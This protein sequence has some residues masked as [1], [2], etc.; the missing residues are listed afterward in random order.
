MSHRSTTLAQH[1]EK[2]RQRQRARRERLRALGA[3]LPHQVDN[4]LSEAVAFTL[5]VAT[6]DKEGVRA[7]PKAQQL[8]AAMIIS[9]ALD[10][11]TKR[12][13]F[14]ADQAAKALV[15]RTSKRPEFLNPYWTPHHPSCEL[16]AMDMSTTQT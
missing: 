15:A 11:L 10:I 2:D 12:W 14:N 16:S 13:K 7:Q 9:T 1:R 8:S 3:P 4:A 5:A 6:S